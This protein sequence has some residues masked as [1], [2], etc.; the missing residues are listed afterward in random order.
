MVH[1]S[2]TGTSRTTLQLDPSVEEFLAEL[3]DAA[4]RVALQHGIAGTF[5]NVQLGLW[6]ALRG[7]FARRAAA[8]EPHV[9]T[10]APVG[11]DEEAV[12]KYIREQEVSP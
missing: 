8:P 12:R 5:I 2:P 3:T 6:S 10:D 4:Y 11:R 7:V 1:H 9:C